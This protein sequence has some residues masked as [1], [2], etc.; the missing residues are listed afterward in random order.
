MSALYGV[1]RGAKGMATRCGH[2]TLETDSACWNGAVR[3]RLENDKETGSTTYR[4]ELVPWHGAGEHRL[5]A[6]GTMGGER[7]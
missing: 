1:I 4:V 5:L 6:E 2:R 7:K 3:V